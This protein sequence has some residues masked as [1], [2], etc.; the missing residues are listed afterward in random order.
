MKGWTLRKLMKLYGKSHS[1]VRSKFL[2]PSLASIPQWSPIRLLQI[3]RRCSRLLPP[4]STLTRG[5]TCLFLPR[6]GPHLG[7]LLL[8]LRHSFDTVR[9]RIL[10][11]Y[12]TDN[13]NLRGYHIAHFDKVHTIPF[14]RRQG[15][16]RVT[17]ITLQ[18]DCQI[19]PHPSR[20]EILPYI[21][22]VPRSSS[23]QGE[24]RFHAC[25]R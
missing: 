16:G 21:F 13:L 15:F 3:S 12:T 24:W 4:S 5:L 6:V 19:H 2:M 9:S 18:G 11:V 25:Y 10:L 20:G 1:I 22:G 17:W 7:E 8:D 23:S 14:Y